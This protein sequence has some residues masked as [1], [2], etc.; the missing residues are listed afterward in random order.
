ML[1]LEDRVTII[2]IDVYNYLKHPPSAKFDLIFADAPYDDKRA[3]EELP[4]MIILNKWIEEDGICVIEHRSSQVMEIVL[5]QG[6]KITRELKAGEAAFTI[7]KY[8]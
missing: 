8:A 5:P 4:S 7:L 2:P 3:L 1:D 6:A